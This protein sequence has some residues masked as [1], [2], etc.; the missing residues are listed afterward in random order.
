M[1]MPLPFRREVTSVKVE[2]RSLMLYFEELLRKAVRV[3]MSCELGTR[4]NL[5]LP[6]CGDQLPSLVL[7]TEFLP[8][9]RNLLSSIRTRSTISLNHTSTLHVSKPSFPAELW[10]NS[11]SFP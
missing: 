9:R 2:V 1:S 5:S 7:N 11:L 4:R 10:I 3:T 6:G 8:S